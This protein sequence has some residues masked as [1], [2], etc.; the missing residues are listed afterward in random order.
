MTYQYLVDG[1]LRIAD[2]F[3]KV[4]L[5]PSHDFE[6]DDR[7]LDE[8]PEYPLDYTS[9]RVSVVDL[10]PTIFVFDQFEKPNKESL[11]I[12]EI[13]L[14][15]FL[16]DHSFVS[17]AD[18]LKYL[19]K[20]GV[21]AIEL[22]PINEFEGN[23]SWGYNPSFHMAVDKYYGSVLDLKQLIN[24]AHELGMA[25]ILD[26]VFNHA[27]SQSPLAQLYWDP[28]KFR[29]SVESPY[30]NPVPKHPFN[31]GYD[32]NH[33][34]KYTKEWVKQI[35]GYWIDEFHF[36][37]FRFDL[38]KGLT[39]K[40]SGDNAQLMA[41]YDPSRI[42][43]LK[44]YSDHI[45]EMDSSAYVIMEHFAENREEKEMAEYG[46]MLWGNMNH[47][48]T[49]LAKGFNQ[50]LAWS[51]YTQRGWSEPNLISYIESHDEE[52]IMYKI[53]NEGSSQ[54]D[55][56][57]RELTTAL[58]RV[59]AASVIYFTTP[60]PKMMWQFG[61]LGYDFSINRCINGQVNGCRLDPK[62]VRWD[63]IE[64]KDRKELYR[65]ISNLIYLRNSFATFTT[66][67]FTFLDKNLFKIV[68]LKH[69]EMD[70]VTMANFR[71]TTSEEQLGFPYSGTWYE[72]FSGDSLV[73]EDANVSLNFLPGEYRIYLSQRITPPN[74]FTTNISLN[75][76]VT[77]VS[78]YPNPITANKIQLNLS[79]NYKV[80]KS[81]I[82]NSD[83]KRIK[84]YVEQIEDRLQI[85]LVDYL[86]P[87]VYFIE[88]IT[89]E[90]RYVS[91][92]V[93]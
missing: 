27:F 52:R 43:I 18:T 45:W 46:M 48:F 37:G 28:T 81:N 9:G 10:N 86:A 30:L 61:E 63:Y 6:I 26:V 39:Q 47:S 91:K 64:N 57:T 67:D 13:L 69:A 36:D 55:Y 65:F 8:L 75:H 33:E 20:L 7:V 72:Y 15:D 85:T 29:P 25:V 51:D 2:P 5:D 24:T 23:Q 22:M 16:A 54:G 40:N 56:N 17:L 77:S 92:F 89:G 90:G 41:N 74:G 35:L 70:A 21:N 66:S 58:R 82:V 78:A 14:R 60:G 73:V 42:N 62:P 79:K 84:H 11:V 3:S 53:L 93:R 71:V 83:G 32:F 19:S 1:S 44:E 31:V 50:N 68:Q 38:S 88:L 49:E 34:S 76:N 59:G 12:Y 4:I 87:G 80:N